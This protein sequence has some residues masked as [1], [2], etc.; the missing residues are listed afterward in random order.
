MAE[1]VY[2]YDSKSYDRKVVWVRVPPAAQNVIWVDQE[3]KVHLVLGVL[4]Q[5]TTALIQKMKSLKEIK[6]AQREVKEKMITLVLD[7]FGLV[8]ALAWNDAI[9]ALFSALFP[10]SGGV[11]GKFA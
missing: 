1:L 11:V 7:G 8:A 4:I 6:K 10:K 3:H 9:Q 2:A 5:P